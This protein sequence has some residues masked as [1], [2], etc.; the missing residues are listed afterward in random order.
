MASRK[1]L[2]SSN[3]VSLNGSDSDMYS[4]VMKKTHHT[5]SL[6]HHLALITS[7]ALVQ[8][9]LFR[10]AAPYP[11]LQ[12]QPALFRA[13]PPY[14]SLQLFSDIQLYRRHWR[15]RI[16]NNSRSPPHY[17]YPCV[18]SLSASS[19][20]PACVTHAT[21]STAPA[22]TLVQHSARP[23]PLQLFPVQVCVL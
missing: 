6:I 15:S 8:P 11:S 3:Y 10:A 20:I 16:P 14:S 1:F 9:A 18:C 19:S 5:S 17:H 13:T 22:T 21:T 7:K 23:L 4:D 12:L 2:L